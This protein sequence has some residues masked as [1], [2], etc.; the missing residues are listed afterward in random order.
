MRIFQYFCTR[1]K[2]VLD[3]DINKNTLESILIM[4]FK[5]QH[6]YAYTGY[7]FEPNLWLV[8]KVFQVNRN[9]ELDVHAWP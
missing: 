3:Q 6:I 7:V 4:T 1:Y 2:R 9:S 8:L 5:S